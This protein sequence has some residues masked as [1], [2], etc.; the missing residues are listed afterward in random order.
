MSLTS[1]DD[2]WSII[3]SFCDLYTINEI[4]K[5]S[6]DFYEFKKF[7]NWKLQFLFFFNNSQEEEEK[8]MNSEIFFRLKMLKHIK[9]KEYFLEE[10][11]KSEETVVKRFNNLIEE[12][13]IPISQK[14]IIPQNDFEKSFPLKQS[15]KITKKINHFNF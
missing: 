3:I 13:I 12:I 14:K 4:K 8:E 10:I 6:K 11:R 2:V 7:I 5:V 15:L 1:T 9:G